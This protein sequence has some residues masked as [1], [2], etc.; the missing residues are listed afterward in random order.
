MFSRR[1]LFSLLPLGA[2][3]VAPAIKAESHLAVSPRT[4]LAWD[5][6]EWRD[7][8]NAYR[9]V[10]E[11]ALAE[12]QTKKGEPSVWVEFTCQNEE[13]TVEVH[14]YARPACGQ[15]FKVVRGP[16]TP[17]CPKC[18]WAYDLTPEEYREKMAGIPC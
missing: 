2:L 8:A 16:V 11:N 9:E 5:A 15:K 10:A 3:G 6:E 17:V 1:R 12:L 13:R 14:G 7:I 18:G 4:G